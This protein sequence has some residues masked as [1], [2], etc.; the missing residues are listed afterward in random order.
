M[1]DGIPRKGKKDSKFKEYK[2][3]FDKCNACKFK[4][5]CA[6][7]RLNRNQGRVIERHQFADY[8]EAN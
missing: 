6:G 4:A 8:T 2:L 7:K 1:V 5:A 3:E